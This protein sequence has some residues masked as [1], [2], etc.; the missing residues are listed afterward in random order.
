[1]DVAFALAIALEAH[2][3]ESIVVLDRARQVVAS[4]GR[5]YPARAL[6]G[7]ASILKD[8]APIGSSRSFDH[9]RVYVEAVVLCGVPCVVAVRGQVAMD[10]P[11]V[12][13]RALQATFPSEDDAP[14]VAEIARHDDDDFEFDLG[15]AESEPV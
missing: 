10:D 5:R 4:A 9:G 14:A 13:T 7:F 1:M 15:W 8:G 3:L 6:E 12:V 11:G 2:A